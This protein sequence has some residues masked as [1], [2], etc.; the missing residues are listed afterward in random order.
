MLRPL[1]LS[2]FLTSTALATTWTEVG[3]PGD[4]CGDAIAISEGMTPYNTTDYTDSGY[5]PDST[6]DLMGIMYR[7][8]W[9]SYLAEDDEPVTI[10][11][12]DSNSFDTSIIV[13]EQN[14]D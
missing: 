2:M 14:Q 3:T 4:T 8:I 6:C 5:S 10:S 1:L 11:T 7:D 9:F 13:Y 12:C